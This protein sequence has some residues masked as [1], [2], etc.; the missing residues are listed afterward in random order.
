[1]STVNS[2]AGPTAEDVR[3]RLI[4]EAA[5]ILGEEGPS[6]L[7]ARRLAAGAGTS[8][9]AVY[10]HFGAMGAVVDAV[11]TEG[12]RRLI[13][14]VDAV[15]RSDDTIAD[16]RQS[17]AA[18]RDNALENRHLFGVM[19]GAISTGGFHGRGPDPEVA[20][21]AFDQIAS[22]I[23][24]AMGAGALLPGDP[25]QVAAQFWSALHGYVMLELSG[26]VRIVDEP[27]QT[28]L[29]PMLAHLLQALAPP[30]DQSR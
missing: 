21:A 25:R 22:G 17:A 20:T 23:E 8:T 15:G 12:F 14:H 24:R 1:M 7:S 26:L 3:A 18:Y 10:T 29:W 4:E 16:L 5:R 27:E 6:A 19:F 9:M 28:V 13:E 11:A 30:P 2:E